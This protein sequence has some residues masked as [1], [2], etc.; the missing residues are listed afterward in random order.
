MATNKPLH[1]DFEFKHISCHIIHVLARLQAKRLVQ[2]QLRAEGRR[3]T[4]VP[5]REISERATAYLASHP[6]VWREAITR[7]HLIDEMEGR[8]KEKR[9]LRSEQ[10]AR[11]VRSVS[12]TDNAKTPTENATENPQPKG[13][14]QGC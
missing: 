13:D 4:L 7:A 3:I 2:E 6:E 5:P 11:L 9:K 14:W 1:P 10:L 8:K 12:R